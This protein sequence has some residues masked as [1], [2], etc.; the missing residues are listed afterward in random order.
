V[1]A[2]RGVRVRVVLDQR[3]KSTNTGAYQYLRAHGVKVVWSSS[4]YTYTHQKTLVI[5][6]SRAVIMTANLTA[7]YYPTTRDF[8]VVDSRRA[9]VTA[10]VKV[11]NADYA[12]RP[13]HPG[14]GRDLVWSPT[15]SHR[16]NLRDRLP[17]REALVL[18]RGGMARTGPGPFASAPIEI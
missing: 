7:R 17:Q 12:H 3:E 9:D 5:D 6:R 1:A 16:Q 10:I 8:L 11:F 14:D 2:R 15:D 18:G 4:T 13:A